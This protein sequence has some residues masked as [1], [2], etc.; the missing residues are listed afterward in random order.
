[1]IFYTDRF[2]PDHA[3]G[4]MRVWLIPIIFIRPAYK[5]DAGLLAHEQVH[6]AQAWRYVFPPIHSLRYK[7]SP[8]YRLMCEVEAY[9]KQLEFSPQ[10]KL[11]YATFIVNDYGLNVS[12]DEVLELL[13]K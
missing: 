1:M 13:G 8:E 3:A 7:W 9:R 5:G 10:H 2:V 6:V 4:C 11:L 12:F